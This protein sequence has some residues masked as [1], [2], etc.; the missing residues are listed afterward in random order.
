[1]WIRSDE[2]KKIRRTSADII[3]EVQRLNSIGDLDEDHQ[4]EAM[5][6]IEIAK[7]LKERKAAFVNTELSIAQAGGAACLTCVSCRY[8]FTEYRNWKRH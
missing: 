3:K 6:L 8:Q 7:Q 4:E 2:D 5:Q 1:M